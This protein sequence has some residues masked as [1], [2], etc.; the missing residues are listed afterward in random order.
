VADMLGVLYLLVISLN[1]WF[2]NILNGLSLE[3]N[4]YVLAGEMYIL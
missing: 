4:L 3:K 1:Y 2:V